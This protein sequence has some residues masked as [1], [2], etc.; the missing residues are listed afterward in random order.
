MRISVIIPCY[1]HNDLLHRC[2]MSVLD[3]GAAEGVEV[4]VVNDGS[5]GGVGCVEQ[6]LTN[7]AS[8]RHIPWRFFGHPHNGALAAGN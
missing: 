5:G 3:N 8:N 6:S 2:V 4:I 1:N 7:A